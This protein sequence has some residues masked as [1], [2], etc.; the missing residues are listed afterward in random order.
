MA[1]GLD[2]ASA[3]GSVPFFSSLKPK[4]LKAMATSGKTHSFKAGEM[5]VER[6]TTGVG[7]FLLLDGRVEVRK[8]S[9][10][11]ATLSRGD[12]FGEM[13]LIDSQPRSADVVA[14]QPTTCYI[15]TAWSFAALVKMHPEIAMA[16]LRELV[17]RLR[18]AQSLATA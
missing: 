1:E 17:K 12:F 5:I 10:I 8:D 6:G 13:A 16:L 9:R 18:A 4:Q 11:L 15:L 7:F 3:I 2:V 14:L